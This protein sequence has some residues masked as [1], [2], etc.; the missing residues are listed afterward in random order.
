MPTLSPPTPDDKALNLKQIGCCEY[1]YDTRHIRLG[2][3]SS[4]RHRA[5]RWRATTSEYR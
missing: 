3:Q 1:E 2:A 5:V 4:P